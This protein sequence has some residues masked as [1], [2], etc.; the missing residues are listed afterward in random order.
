MKKCYYCG[1]V[2]EGRFKIC[3]PCSYIKKLK[4]VKYNTYAS[5]REWV[6]K[7]FEKMKE[8]RRVYYWANKERICAQNKEYRSRNK[9][10]INAR[11]REYRAAM[12][13]VEY[14]RKG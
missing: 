10:A 1:T 6:K 13:A 5:Q 11:R 8:Y 4:T 12:R 2:H 9:E 3:R 14:W 7:N